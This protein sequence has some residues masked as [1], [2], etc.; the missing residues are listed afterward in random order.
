MFPGKVISFLTVRNLI[1][2]SWL[3]KYAQ[4]LFSRQELD[5]INIPQEVYWRD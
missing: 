5:E 2:I 4:G 1:I 3:R